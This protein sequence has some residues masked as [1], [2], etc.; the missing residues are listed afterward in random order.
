MYANIETFNWYNHYQFALSMLCI[1]HACTLDLV[2][3]CK[4]EST[5]MCMHAFYAT[6]VKYINYWWKYMFLMSI[7]IL[8]TLKCTFRA[9]WFDLW[10]E[11]QKTGYPEMYILYLLTQTFVFQIFKSNQIFQVIIPKINENSCSVLWW[12]FMIMHV[13]ATY[14]WNMN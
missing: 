11:G 7:K 4:S 8:M 5:C 3:T 1:L 13:Y 2:L 6:H 10:V 12:I 9:C 14:K